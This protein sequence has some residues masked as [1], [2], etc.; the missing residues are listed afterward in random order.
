MANLAGLLLTL[1]FCIDR[2]DWAV[3]RIGSIQI[4]HLA[5]ANLCKCVTQDYPVILP[6]CYN[7]SLLACMRIFCKRN[8]LLGIHLSGKH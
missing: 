8:L 6:S 5:S 1:I 7:Q 4:S 2:R 3:G